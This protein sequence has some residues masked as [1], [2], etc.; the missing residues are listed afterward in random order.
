MSNEVGIVS[1]SLIAP[2][3]MEALVIQLGGSFERDDAHFP[4]TIQKDGSA[5]WIA[6]SPEGIPI[7]KEVHGDTLERRLGARIQTLIVVETTSG[8]AAY[9]IAYAFTE[10]VLKK[11]PSVAILPDDELLSSEDLR[12]AAAQ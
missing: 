4:W 5:I 11:F 3:E 7:S 10:A 8:D 1:S 2:S 9:R 6:L 12:N